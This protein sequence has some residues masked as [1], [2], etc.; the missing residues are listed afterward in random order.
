[1]AQKPPGSCKPHATR[2]NVAASL[3]HQKAEEV[4]GDQEEFSKQLSW[5]P[6]G[7]T[8]ASVLQPCLSQ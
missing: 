6:A 5:N 1:M 7:S 2:V 8:G 3:T 4:Q